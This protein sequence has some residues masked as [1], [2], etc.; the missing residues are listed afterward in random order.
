VTGATGQV[1]LLRQTGTM[2]QDFILTQ[3]KLSI[4]FTAEARNWAQG[5]NSIAVLIDGVALAF[6]G[7]TS[8][9]PGSNSA[10]TLYTSDF[11][12]LAAGIHTL[13]ITWAGNGQSTWAASPAVSSS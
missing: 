12:S 2:S 9:L 1:A 5:G 11:V 6:A 8:I 4:A 13:S 3:N 10:F 7:A